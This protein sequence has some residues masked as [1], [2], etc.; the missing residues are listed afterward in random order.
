[1]IQ[2]IELFSGAGGMAL[3]LHQ[4][5]AQHKLLAELDAKACETIRV[6]NQ[7]GVLSPPWP[8]VQQ[9]VRHLDLRQWE[10][11]V[12]L[13]AAGAPCQPFSLGGRHKGADDTRNLLPE[14]ARAIR[15]VKPRAFMLENVPGLLRPS[16]AEY[17]EY[18]LSQLQV[19]EVERKET[20]T[21]WEHAVRVNSHLPRR[22]FGL[23]YDVEF[24]ILSAAD[25]GIPQNRRRL[26]VI[27]RRSDVRS[28]WSWP[29][30][31][32]S[33]EGLLYSKWVDGSYWQYHGLRPK[34]VPGEL[35]RRISAL[36]DRKP[37]QVRWQ[38]VRDALQGLPSPANGS[39]SPSVPNHQF[40]PGA[41]AYK[42]HSGSNPDEPAKTL[43][44]GV[45]GVPGGEG[46]LVQDDGSLRYFTVR[47]AARLQTFPD[48]F[49]FVGARSHAM[50]QI[51]NAVP[52]KLAQVV[53]TAAVRMLRGY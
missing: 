10:G 22:Q 17:F 49:A 8:I 24:R 33:E 35:S 7:G 1:M 32:H 40:V 18:F 45:H 25:Y 26:F 15:Q 29:K 41:R 30:A 47:E 12:D 42:G 53:G 20:E 14:V 21:W 3:G 46:T 16:F 34:P 28:P 36:S 37:P 4:I 52:V 27:G 51:G 23:G 50:R 44:A 2:T 6:N 13:L 31:T 48:D 43:K 19:P 11:R 39:G 38:T 5:G 9:D